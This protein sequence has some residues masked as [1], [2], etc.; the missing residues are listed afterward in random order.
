MS[1]PGQNVLWAALIGSNLGWGELWN[2]ETAPTLPHPH[3]T[4][5]CLRVLPVASSSAGAR[6]GGSLWQDTICPGQCGERS[7][8]KD[9]GHTPA[10][11]RLG[12]PLRRA[13][14]DPQ[15]V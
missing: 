7:M 10:G 5:A 14:F 1:P 15:N 13:V 8:A 3:C 6:L 2:K 4:H 11:R 12:L 9:G